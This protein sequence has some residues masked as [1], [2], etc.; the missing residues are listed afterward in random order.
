MP[1]Y[2]YICEKCEHE[3]EVLSRSMSDR[4]LPDCP[5]CGAARVKRRMSVFAA[6]Q[7][8]ATKSAIG[9]GPG[10]GRCGDPEGPCAL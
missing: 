7:D 4:A 6:R 5:A 10:C 1:V 3:F 8:T 9:G 2:E